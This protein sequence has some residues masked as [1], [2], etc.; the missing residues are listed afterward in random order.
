M[1]PI[2]QDMVLSL[3]SPANLMTFRMNFMCIVFYKFSI[4]TFVTWVREITKLLLTLV[5][6][7]ASPKFKISIPTSI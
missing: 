3:G 7:E 5:G 2:G 6:H 4:L 1:R